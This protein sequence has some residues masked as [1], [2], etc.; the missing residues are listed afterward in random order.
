MRSWSRTRVS[1]ELIV[2]IIFLN[3]ALHA[4]VTN[5][6]AIIAAI[7]VEDWCMSGRDMPS[8][9]DEVWVPLWGLLYYQ[10]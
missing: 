8:M 1:T 10:Y 9:T 4:N 3:L 2:F 7:V 5:I 6:S